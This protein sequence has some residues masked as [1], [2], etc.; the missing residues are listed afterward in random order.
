MRLHKSTS[1][2]L[3]ILLDCARAETE[4]VKV[5]DISARLGITLQNVFKI[6]HI[7]SNAGLVTGQRGPKGGIRLA[8]PPSDIR[9]GDVVRAMQA[10]NMEIDLDDPRGEGIDSVN[11][12]LDTAFNAFIAILDDHTLADMMAPPRRETVPSMKGQRGKRPV[13][14]R[15]VTR[16]VRR[17]DKP[18]TAK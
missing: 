7:L 16:G 1:H 14:D 2:A 10:T 13:V 3:R 11:R 17:T 8:L 12:V 4:F 18:T 9:I 15:A 6:V 5:A